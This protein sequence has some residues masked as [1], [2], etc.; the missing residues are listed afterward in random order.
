MASKVIY[1]EDDEE[2]TS[3][4]DR[5]KHSDGKRIALVIPR[6]AAITSSV[7]SLKLLKKTADDLSKELFLVASDD[8]SRTLIKRAGLV[9]YSKIDKRLLEEPEEEVELESEE[10]KDSSV[11]NVSVK[12]EPKKPTLLD[13]SHKKTPIS[14][15]LSKNTVTP[16]TEP[17]K[18]LIKTP[19]VKIKKWVVTVIILIVL[20]GSAGVLAFSMPNAS[21]S[22]TIAS[23]A[24]NYSETYTVKTEALEVNTDDLVLPGEVVELE[25]EYSDSAK[26]TG[27]KTVG[28]KA[29]GT[30]TVSNE[31]STTT[32]TL[33][34]GTVFRSSGGLNFKTKSAVNVPGYTDP[35]GGKVPGQANVAVEAS[36]IGAGYNIGAGS[37]V[38]P[39]F[40]GTSKYTEIYGTSSSAMTGG[41]SRQATVVSS[42]DV[43]K[44]T[45][46]L[47]EASEKSIYEEL[48]AQIDADLSLLP[49]AVAYTR[50]SADSDKSEGTETETF[51]VSITLKAVAIIYDSE[52][53][54]N[55]ISEDIKSNIEKN[56]VLAD[57]DLKNLSVSVKDLDLEKGS[58]QLDTSIEA[59]IAPEIDESV[60]KQNIAGRSIKEAEKYL[61]NVDEVLDVEVRVWPD[62]W[63]KSIPVSQNKIKVKIKYQPAETDEETE[64]AEDTE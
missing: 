51:N 45:T 36:A 44:S 32:Q 39:A 47:E 11:E 60:L 4:I 28:T 56:Q 22:I 34:A 21:A 26:A 59:Q 46:T 23:E 15:A 6:N 58:M 57:E 41:T 31:Y 19:K 62:W 35:G 8:T 38:I 13:I 17:K 55:L 48:T 42:S 7:V 63:F 9:A 49:E 27:T 30:I 25:K 16:K 1:L 20:L 29:T 43:S 40:A 50:I 37:F 33:A 10:Q 53:L 2:I 5:L 3:V 24:I 18:P 54:K 12:K 14:D 64:P 52:D 61:K